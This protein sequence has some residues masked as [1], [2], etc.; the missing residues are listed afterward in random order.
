[1]PDNDPAGQVTE[2]LPVPISLTRR[3]GDFV[4]VSGLGDH[5]FTP[6]DVTFNADGSVLNDGSGLGPRGIEQQTRSVFE[7]IAAALGQ[8]NC[9]LADIVE[10]TVWLKD[11]R[12]FIS[13]NDTYKE[14]FSPPLPTRAIVRADFMFDAL[15]EVKATAYKPRG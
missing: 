12:D 8:E 10:M 1:M 5:Y 9:D 15:V 7:R 13:F 4:F 3:A 2:D 6:E 11:P 14:F